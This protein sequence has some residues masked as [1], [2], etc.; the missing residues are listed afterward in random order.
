MKQRLS[1]IVLTYNEASRLLPCLESVTWADEI[2]V[3]DGGSTDKTVEIAEKFTFH[4]YVSTLL[5]PDNPGGFSDQRNFALGKASG[6]WVL[7]LDADERVTPELAKEIQTRILFGASAT[8]PVYDIRRKEHFFGIYSPHTHGQAW[9]ARLLRRGYAKW[10]G[11]RVHEGL[12]FEGTTGVLHQYIQHFSK[13][14]V[15]HYVSTMNRYTSL[16][17]EEAVKN[18]QPLARTPWRGMIHAFCYRYF[19]LGSYREGTFGL[20]MSLM[21]GFYSYLSWTKHWE[22]CKNAGS[23]P[24]RTRPALRTAFTG[25]LL[26]GVWIGFGLVKK[27]SRR[28]RRTAQ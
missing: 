27:G 23:I 26:R 17:A 15:A 9:Q 20:V 8:H 21:F 2:I 16:E 12:I 19:H 24:G 11:R 5:G 14:T 7:F 1:V 4:V 13:E 28:L 6:D 10:D 22:L 25:G 3:V 18:N